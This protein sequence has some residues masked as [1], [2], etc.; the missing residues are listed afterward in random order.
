MSPPTC[1]L[2]PGGH[3]RRNGYYSK[4]SRHI[5]W[6]CVPADGSPAHLVRPDP[7]TALKRAAKAD[8]PA[9]TSTPKVAG[10]DAVR[11]ERGRAVVRARRLVGGGTDLLHQ[12][13]EV[14][15]RVLESWAEK[16]GSAWWADGFAWRSD[17]DM[18]YRATMFATS[19]QGTKMLCIAGPEILL[20]L[21][22]TVQGPLTKIRATGR[23]GKTMS[24]LVRT[25]TRVS[26][27]GLELRIFHTMIDIQDPPI[28]MLRPGRSR[29]AGAA[30]WALGSPER[31]I[32]P[33]CNTTHR[34]WE[35][36][37]SRTLLRTPERA[38]LDA[39]SEDDLVE[40]AEAIAAAGARITAASMLAARG[41]DA[42]AFLGGR[43]VMGRRMGWL[44][45]HG[46]L[47]RLDHPDSE[48]AYA[49]AA[50]EN[51]TRP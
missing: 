26:A 37:T 51:A 43:E 46:R 48:I 23:C 9:S 32:C 50:V 1:V 2:H 40:T 34:W 14:Y 20:E 47:V 4:G 38:E 22:D 16:D 49:L 44:V 18:R 12:T 29:R 8:R 25:Q 41:Y 45:R 24:K 31:C 7:T 42:L 15:A 10:R 6:E 36:T 3:V 33:I 21:S 27:A 30:E 13:S 17:D 39:L 35:E 11:E 19:A 28:L 5:R